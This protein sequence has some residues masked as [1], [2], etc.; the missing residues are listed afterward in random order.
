ML[1]MCMAFLLLLV[2]AVC[3]VLGQMYLCRIFAVGYA[4]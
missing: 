3:C 2:F 1:S 4:L